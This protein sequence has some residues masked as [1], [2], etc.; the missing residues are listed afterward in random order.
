MIAPLVRSGLGFV[1]VI[2]P[3]TGVLGIM[4]W[5]L[6]QSDGNPGSFGINK[7]FGEVPIEEREA[8]SI[9]LDLLDG[10]TLELS[11][12]KGKLV[13]V[14]FWSSWCPPC[15]EEAPVLASV[16]TEYANRDVEFIGIAIWDDY[17]EVQRYVDR[18]GFAY[19]NGIDSRGIMAVSYGVRGLPEKYFIDASGK[20]IRKFIGPVTEDKL[21]AILDELIENEKR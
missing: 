9:S 6:L 11:E 3:V 20:L 4:A 7:V 15:I 17:Q 14:D 2:L 13:M 8:P 19:H 10:G 16:Y 1:L 18:A 5:A 21:R 12:F